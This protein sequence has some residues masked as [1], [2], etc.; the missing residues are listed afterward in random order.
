MVP[1]LDRKTPKRTGR[2]SAVPPADRISSS[3]SNKSS[4]QHQR[5]AGMQAV[6]EL[7]RQHDNGLSLLKTT[8]LSEYQMIKDLT[9]D[10]CIIP[11]KTQETQ[12]WP[13]SG[14]DESP[15]LV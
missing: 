8:P 13:Y 9:Y 11:S 7:L 12:N 6:F 4:V 14:L 15:Q 1:I 2:N 10:L 3:P 5:R